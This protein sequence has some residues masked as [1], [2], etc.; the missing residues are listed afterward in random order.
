MTHMLRWLL[1]NVGLLMLAVAMAVVLW[2]ISSLQDDPIIE[3]PVQYR[4]QLQGEERLNDFV[5]TSKIP[6]TVDTVI[7]AGRSKLTDFQASGPKI[8]VDLVELGPGQHS[9]LLV[10]KAGISPATFI[11]T[12]VATA[13]ISIERLQQARIPVHFSTSGVPAVGFRVGSTKID[14]DQ[15]LAIAPQSVLTRVAA[16]NA[17]VTVDGLR[18]SMDVN[19]QRLVAV[20]ANGIELRDV[21]LVPD[22]VQARIGVEQ[23][24]NYRDL[25]VVVKWRGQ[26][27]E[28]YSVADIS[29]EPIIVTVFGRDNAVQGTKGFI[30]TLDV[31]ID[32]KQDDVDERVGV[33]VPPGVS[34]VSEGQTVRVRMRVRPL[35]G[36]RSVKRR[37]IFLGLSTTLS[38]T[39]QPAQVD[40]V[41]T[42][43]L[44]RLNK[45]TEDDVRATIDVVGLDEGSFQLTPK[46][47]APDGVTASSLLP[48]AVQVDLT[49]PKK[50]P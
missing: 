13:T 11:S 3:A 16:V 32:N 40:I 22:T 41:L 21:K 48:A 10:P 37:P 36:S 33:N 47:V 28:G 26:P 29:V 49:K 1:N 18:A 39:V 35:I 14:P 19:A 44:P 34:L 23:L 42:G 20:D 4:V 45:L 31:V 12:Q 27:A 7:R 46:V 43:P 17:F 2:V 24:S 38:A 25:P 9:F 30:E 15:V 5:V 6:T 8:V 50:K